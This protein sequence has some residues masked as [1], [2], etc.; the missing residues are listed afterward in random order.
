MAIDKLLQGSAFSQNEVANMTAAY[1]A[2][3]LLLRL[4]DRN[5]D[6]ITERLAEKIVAIA[7]SG[8]QDPSHICARAIDELGLPVA[9]GPVAPGDRSKPDVSS[10]RW[11]EALLFSV[12]GVIFGYVFAQMNKAVDHPAVLARC[13]LQ[14]QTQERIALCMRAAGY[15]FS[16]TQCDGAEIVSERDRLANAAEIN[17]A[18]IAILEP[19]IE[20]YLRKNPGQSRTVAEL[21]VREDAREQLEKHQPAPKYEAVASCYRHHRPKAAGS[22]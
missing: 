12:I 7:R 1:E 9:D 21:M 3:L 8:E 18:R 14:E 5:N 4:E 6:P 2:A 22:N 10:F 16:D 13:K 17:A 11:R 15:E 20:Q 19:F